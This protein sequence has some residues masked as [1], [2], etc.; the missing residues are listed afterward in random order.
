MHVRNCIKGGAALAG[1]AILLGTAPTTIVSVLSSV[2]Q[3]GGCS[4]V[5]D[6][7]CLSLGQLQGLGSIFR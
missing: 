7:S 2:A 6:F 5:V 4:E 1:A 3:L